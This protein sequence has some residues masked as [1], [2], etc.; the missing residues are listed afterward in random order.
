MGGETLGQ[1][2]EGNSAPESSSSAWPRTF[3]SL[4]D[5]LPNVFLNLLTRRSQTP[6][7]GV[8]NDAAIDDPQIRAIKPQ[9]VASIDP[10]DDWMSDRG[11]QG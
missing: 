2:P 10:L 7:E 1:A 3:L 6:S 8:H 11:W 9:D 4:F 5:R